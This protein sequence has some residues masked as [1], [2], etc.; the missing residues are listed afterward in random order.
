[1]RN[2]YIFIGVMI[3]IL[4]FIFACCIDPSEP[5]DTAE[6]KITD[7]SKYVE[8]NI[9]SNV[10]QIER[11][12]VYSI[13]YSELPITGIFLV[14]IKNYYPKPIYNV[15]VDKEFILASNTTFSV[16]IKKCKNG[17]NMR[18]D[19]GENSEW[20]NTDIVLMNTSKTFNFDSTI[21]YQFVFKALNK[22]KGY[23][24]FI[25]EDKSG[26]VSSNTSHGL[27][28]GYTV[29]PLNPLWLKIDDIEWIYNTEKGSFS[30]VSVRIKGSTNAYRLRGV[31]GGD[32]ILN[33]MEIPIQS[34]QSFEVK[35][36]VAFSYVEG[37]YLK[38]NSELLLYGTVGLPK[39]ISLINPKSE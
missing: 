35:I 24:S 29:I 37:I 2:G 31:T 8:F 19:N 9:N 4:S 12:P 36:P 15:T 25:E 14:S 18:V 16:E 34:D 23:I 5:A 13:D 3:L 39:I 30:K 27:V 11:T 10:C 32:G 38:T 20:K 1:M 33:S 7:K 21:N 26:S 17:F 22:S 6:I 28:I